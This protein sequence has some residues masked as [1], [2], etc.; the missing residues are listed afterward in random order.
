MTEA[1][2]TTDGRDVEGRGRVAR[3]LHA[4]GDKLLFVVVGGFKTVVGLGL[5]AVIVLLTEQ[6]LPG[7][8]AWIQADIAAVIT[9]I[10]S[11]TISWSMFKLFVFRTRGTNWLRE[12]ARSY[13]VYFPSLV[14]N[15]GALSALVGLLHLNKILA[16]VIWAVFM[17]VY[18]WFGHKWFT[19]GTP[20]GTPE[21][22]PT[23]F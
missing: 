19:F 17:A 2:P 20:K 6:A 7:V 9:W 23:G 18:S 4:H 22:E 10:I 16:Q 14:M 8:A 12:W 3:A 1:E 5:Y 11:V 15:L 21:E 13:L